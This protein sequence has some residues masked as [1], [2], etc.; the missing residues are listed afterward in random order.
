MNAETDELVFRDSFVRIAG[1]EAESSVD[2][3]GLRY[4]IFVQGCSHHCSGCHNP[5]THDFYGGQVTDLWT[6]VKALRANK[7]LKGLTI[8][9][10]EPFLQ[11]LPLTMLAKE[12]H[13]SGLDV[14]CYSGYTYEEL[15]YA[16]DAGQHVSELLRQVDYLIDGSFIEELKDI[17]L[18][19]RGSSNQRIL[20]MKDGFMTEE[21]GEL[22]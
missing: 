1:V 9:G 16:A 18:S 19:I 22:T 4:V 2:G 10:G 20:V 8:S 3:P 15:R 7:L 6:H 21:L 17:S 14:I 12:A 5:T 11:P 13:R